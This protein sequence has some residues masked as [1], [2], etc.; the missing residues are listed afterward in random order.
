MTHHHTENMNLNTQ[1][2]NTAFYHLGRIIA[3]LELGARAHTE[4]RCL[5]L[6]YA[7]GFIPWASLREPLQRHQQSVLP[8]LERKGT[9]D[10]YRESLD[11]LANQLQQDAG[12]HTPLETFGTWASTILSYQ[13]DKPPTGIPT[14]SLPQDAPHL[15]PGLPGPAR[16]LP[17]HRPPPPH[18]DD[19]LA[20]HWDYHLGRIMPWNGAGNDPNLS[21]AFQLG[22]AD[23]RALQPKPNQGQICPG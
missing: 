8:A 7:L 17:P 18:K 6:Y 3:V 21:T 2:R 4:V 5:H 11:L 12:L 14:A 10:R 22:L 1:P 13:A 15:R 16:L 20:Y 19:T 23:Q 9:G